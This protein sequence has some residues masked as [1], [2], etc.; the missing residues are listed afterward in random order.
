MTYVQKTRSTVTTI[1]DYLL[2]DKCKVRLFSKRTDSLP[3]RIETADSDMQVRCYICKNISNTI[4]I[5]LKSMLDESSKYSFE[6]FAVGT[7]V[8]SSVVDRDDHIRSKFMLIGTDGIKTSITRELT[9]R[10]ARRTRKIQDMLD[11]DLTLTVNTSDGTCKIRTKTIIIQGRYTKTRRGFPQKAVPCKSCFGEGCKECDFL[12]TDDSESVEKKISEI[13]T[14]KFGCTG[15]KFTWIGGEDKSSLVL[16]AGRPFFARLQNPVRKCPRLERKIQTDFVELHRCQILNNFPN[17]P[18]RFFSTIKITVMTE[19][20]HH[21]TTLKRLKE[22]FILPVT[23]YDDSGRRIKKSVRVIRYRRLSECKLTITIDAEG[24]L[25]V[26][27]FVKGDNVTPSIS[28]VL[29][30]TCRC[31]QFDFVDIHQ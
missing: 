3:D 16:G 14:A 20:Q 29:E 31:V 11:P 1:K 28:Q 18:I 21:S 15:I 12:G 19:L 8:K 30:D 22:R 4:N 17:M 5:Y 23:V 7:H 25:P 26:R 10:F 27:R 13:L 9:R 6:T 2:C 24:G